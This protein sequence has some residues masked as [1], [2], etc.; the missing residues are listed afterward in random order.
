MAG[1]RSIYQ[2]DFVA[3]TTTRLLSVGES[4]EAELSWEV[5]QSSARYAAINAPWA[6]YVAEGA[7]DVKI[8][9]T[10]YREHATHAALRSACMALA[11]ALPSG[12]SGIL[13]IAI[14]GGDT[15][16]IG[17]AVLLSSRA[18]PLMSSNRYQSATSYQ[19]VG[20]AMIKTA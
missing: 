13:R 17:N 5:A 12:K 10:T 9:W 2:I 8:S 4:L 15:W 3:A 14:S 20:G 1:I 7:A 18:T 6:E 11:A 16:E 19:A